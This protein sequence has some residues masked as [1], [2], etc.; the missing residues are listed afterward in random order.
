MRGL[1][2]ITNENIVSSENFIQYSEQAIIGGA[3][4]IQYRNKHSNK[5]IT[6]I[7]A[8][9][10]LCLQYQ[11]PLIIN[12][13]IQLAKQI[14]ADGVH[15]G[16]EDSQLSTARSILGNKAIIGISCYNKIYLAKQAVADGANYVAFGSFFSSPTK[17]Q[18]TQCDINTLKQA[19]KVLN[20]PI[21]AIGGITPD[22][23]GDLI[24]AGADCLAVISGIFDQTNITVAAQ[25]YTELF[26]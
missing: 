24:M 11:V 26:Q 3:K 7:I 19:R 25:K 17:P 2:A 10:K 5:N 4:V 23:G 6:Q 22:N 8:L 15:L 14:G 18:A 9:K 12:D 16:K 21:V 13:D 1:Y 20:C